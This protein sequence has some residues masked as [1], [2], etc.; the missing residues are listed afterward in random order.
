MEYKENQLVM[1][2]DGDCVF[3][4]FKRLAEG[5][6]KIEGLDGGLVAVHEGDFRNLTK[7]EKESEVG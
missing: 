4:L 7:E 5:Y 6:W 1:E 2:R 3:L